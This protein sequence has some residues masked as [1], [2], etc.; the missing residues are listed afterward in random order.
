[1]PMIAG[2]PAADELRR[3]GLRRMRAVAGGLL[4]LAAMLVV[5]AA[6]RRKVEGEVQHLAV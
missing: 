5:E 6:P 3:S 4:V 1:M 2:D